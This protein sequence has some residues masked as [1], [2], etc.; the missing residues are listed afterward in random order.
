[1]TLSRTITVLTY[2]ACALLGGGIVIAGTGAALSNALFL[3]DAGMWL[4]IATFPVYAA[5]IV[6][7]VIEWTPWRRRKE[8]ERF[9]AR[10]DRIRRK[11]EQGAA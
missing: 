5:L 10:L 9:L 4:Q 2:V 8:R 7:V 1:M 6:L 3:F 11:A